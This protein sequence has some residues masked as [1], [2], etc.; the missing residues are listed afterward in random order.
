MQINPQAAHTAYQQV[1]IGSAGPLR[2]VV[3]LYEGAIQ[4]SRQAL[5]KFDEP[6]VRGHAL[7][8]AHSI[9]SELFATLDHE[10]GEQIATN[11]DSL[12]GFVLDALT[13]ATVDGDRKALRDALNVLK[14]LLT[15]WRTIEARSQGGE[16]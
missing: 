2:I 4:F 10:Q 9:V 6:A 3:L 1:Q 12:Y 11:L 16:R 7:G 13:R 8:R 15:A 5:E 14:T